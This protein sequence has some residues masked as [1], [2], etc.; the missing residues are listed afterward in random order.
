M[1]GPLYLG[2]IGPPLPAEKPG[3]PLLAQAM[4]DRVHQSDVCPR[5]FLSFPG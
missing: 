3:S 4:A 2:Q 1:V 5:K